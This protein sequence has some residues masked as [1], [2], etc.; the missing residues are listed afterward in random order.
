MGKDLVVEQFVPAEPEQVY[1]AWLSPAQLARWWWPHIPDT[2]YS[3]AARVGGSYEI[4]SPSVGIGARG[5][6]LALH[7]P[8][9]IELTWNWLN[10]G[11]SAVT[12]HVT[13]EFAK[14]LHGTQVILTHTLSE[15]AGDGAD[16][17]QGW[18]DVLSRLPGL[19]TSD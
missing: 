4:S 18:E 2:T 16:L 9:R 6:F 12:E 19:F 15:L 17:R 13:V 7:E 3:V 10:D 14:R 11:V 8:D 5:D 1:A